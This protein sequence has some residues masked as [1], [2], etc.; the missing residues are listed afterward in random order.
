[1]I[2]PDG[3]QNTKANQG[4]AIIQVTLKNSD[5]YAIDITGAQYDYYDAVIPWDLY[6]ASRVETIQEVQAL[7]S[8]KE[9]Q[10]HI[11]GHSE[12]IEMDVAEIFGAAAK[13][14][15]AENGPLSAMLKLRDDHFVSKQ[16]ELLDSIDRLVREQKARL[17]AKYSEGF[18][19]GR[20]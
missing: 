20:L 11:N 12:T 17:E 3:H 2:N 6:I 8:I 15:P 14:W 7:G 16:A 9:R 13:A 18:G 1:M 4:H 5:I 10:E 19:N